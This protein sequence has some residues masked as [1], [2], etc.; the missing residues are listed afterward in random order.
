MPLLKRFFF[1]R[2][3]LTSRLLAGADVAGSLANAADALRELFNFEWCRLTV[4]D[5]ADAD[6]DDDMSAAAGN[7]SIAG[8]GVTLVAQADDDI[9]EADIEV[10]QALVAGIAAG[11]DRLRLQEEVRNARLIAEVGRQRAGFLSAVSHNLR[12]PLTAVKAAAGTLL[13]SWSRIDPDERRELLETISDEAERL[14][15]LVRNTLELSRIR[16]GALE[17]HPQP[18]DIR[19]LV[20]HA[21]RREG[22]VHWQG[23]LSLL[24]LTPARLAQAIEGFGPDVLT[25]KR[26]EAAFSALDVVCHM[27][28]VE[29]EVYTPRLAQLLGP[30]AAEPIV[31]NR[32]IAP[33]T[34]PVWKLYQVA[35]A[36]MNSDRANNAARYGRASRDPR[37]PATAVAANAANTGRL[38]KVFGTPS[39]DDCHW[40]KTLEQDRTA[41]KSHTEAAS[42]FSA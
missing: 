11:V 33:I 30:S 40:P 32:H 37:I 36:A 15:R 22:E 12:T 39:A 16:A 6:S 3:D 14:E 4:A 29:A 34:S 20:Q 10:L 18:V 17:F 28:D 31:Q 21:V 42:A 24:E 26:S 2:L 35:K 41:L 8:P 27:R 19:D 9:S 25:K 13:A 5:E 7:L 38:I 1:L 23:L